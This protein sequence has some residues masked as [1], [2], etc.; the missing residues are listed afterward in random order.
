MTSDS[1]QDISSLETSVVPPVIQTEE[2]FLEAKAALMGEQ[3]AF[4]QE[5]KFNELAAHVHKAL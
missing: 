4:R 5:E 1:T 2:Q 3:K